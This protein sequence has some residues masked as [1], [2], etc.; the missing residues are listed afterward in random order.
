M[1]CGVVIGA[2][3]AVQGGVATRPDAVADALSAGWRQVNADPEA[4]LVVAL[5]LDQ[6]IER[7]QLAPIRA[8]PAEHAQLGGENAIRQRPKRDARAV[9]RRDLEAVETLLR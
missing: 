9:L 1:G 7:Q 6:K 4:R 8:D 3:V 5:A 2:D